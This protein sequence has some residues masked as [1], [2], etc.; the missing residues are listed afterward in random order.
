MNEMKV[1]LPDGS[2][3]LSNQGATVRDIVASWKKGTLSGAV[4]AKLDN[5]SVDLS[6]TVLEP[7]TIS[8]IDVES[9]EGSR[10]IYS[11]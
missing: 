1:V 8:L 7:A 3:S 11:G 9:K 5:E 10:T 2:V 4:A 6:Q